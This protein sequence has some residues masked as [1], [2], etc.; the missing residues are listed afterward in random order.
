MTGKYD[1][2]MFQLLFM[3]WPLYWLILLQY[4]VTL[5]FSVA[6]D[7]AIFMLHLWFGGCGLTATLLKCLLIHSRTQIKGETPFRI[8]T[9]K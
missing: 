9:V 5:K 8:R 4:Q 7:N 6:Y 2:Y 3:V 1:Y